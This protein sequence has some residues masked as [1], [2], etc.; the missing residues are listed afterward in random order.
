MI[1]Q[2]KIFSWFIFGISSV[3]VGIYPIIYFLN[4]GQY[5][6]LGSKSAALLSNSFYTLTFYSH[7]TF[8]GLALLTG[9]VQFSERLQRTNIRFHRTIGTTYAVSV[10]LSGT[11]GGYIAFYA[12]G[13]LIT[14]LGFASLAIIWLTTTIAG[15]SAIRR[16]NIGLHQKMMIYSYAACFAAVTLRIWLPLLEMLTGSFI[17]AYRIVSWLAWVPNLIV[18]YFINSRKKLTANA[19]SENIN[20]VF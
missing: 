18:A 13:G 20:T 6:I 8:G 1:S 14:V 9:W 12:T 10:L 16:N 7:I 17:D 2:R 11:C 4:D 5:G 19:L 3:V 15:F